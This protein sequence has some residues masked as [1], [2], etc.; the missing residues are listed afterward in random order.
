V[1]RKKSSKKLLKQ[2]YWYLSKKGYSIG[3]LIKRL[4]LFEEILGYHL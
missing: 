2:W 3:G 4:L 1:D